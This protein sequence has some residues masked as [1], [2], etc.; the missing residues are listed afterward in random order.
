MSSKYSDASAPKEAGSFELNRVVRPNIQKLKPYRCARDDYSEGQLMDANENSLGPPLHIEHTPELERYP[1]PHQPKL[2]TL[3]GNWRGVK[4][5]QVFVGV[6]SDE[7][8]DLIVRMACV[9][10]K[11]FILTLPPTY[12]MYGVCAQVNDVGVVEVPLEKEDFSLDPKKIVD[13]I[14]SRPKESPV[15]VV[16]VCHPNNPTGNDVASLACLEKLAGDIG[17][18]LLVIDEAYVDFSSRPSASSLVSRCPNVIVLQTFSK[19]WGLAGI[20]C[21]VA[22]ADE[23]II[24]YL[25]KMKAPYN[26]NKITSNIAVRAMGKLDVLTKRIGEIV[27]ER[28][29]V[30]DALSKM[31]VV[32]KV[33]PSHSNFLLFRLKNAKRVHVNMADA[34]VVI[35]YR[36]GAT[37]CEECLRVSIGSQKEN[38]NFLGALEKVTLEAK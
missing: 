24:D 1:C 4:K 16:F 15:K 27:A 5:E 28:N 30:R 11:D 10:Q 20:R 13:A 7:A 14:K 29:R 2:K 25:T 35:R 26:L 12:G 33:W 19:S 21:G 17:D 3:Y 9:P 32:E 23:A 18:A 37:N 36:G 34:G 22:M 38:D 8:I 6:G 31:D